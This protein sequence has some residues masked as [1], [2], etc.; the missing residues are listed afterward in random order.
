MGLGMLGLERERLLVSSQSGIELLQ[1]LIGIGQIIVRLGQVRFEFQR[2]AA[3]GNGFVRAADID[4]QGGQAHQGAH[5]RRLQVQRLPIVCFGFGQAPQLAQGIGQIVVRV[6][7]MRCQGNGLVAGIDGF[8]RQSHALQQVSEIDPGAGMTRRRGNRLATMR[9]RC[10]EVPLICQRVGQIAMRIGQVRML[11]ERLAVTGD[12][13]VEHAVFALRRAEI[14][15]G[16]GIVGQQ[17]GRFLRGMQRILALQ[18]LRDTQRFPYE[19]R[20]G[21][22]GQQGLCRLFQIGVASGAEQRQQ[23]VDLDLRRGT[24]RGW[25]P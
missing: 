22:T 5:I 23:L 4:Q 24:H 21:R 6:G 7:M 20:I 16:L 1:F 14:Q 13:R 25:H 11:H 15:M 17:P 8:L 3:T 2:R 18:F 12:C 9:H 19:T 10:V